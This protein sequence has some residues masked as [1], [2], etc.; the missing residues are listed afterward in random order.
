[1][2]IAF[3]A[4]SFRLPAPVEL[5]NIFYV[6]FS[7]YNDTILNLSSGYA[8]SVFFYGLVVY[9]PELSRRKRIRKHALLAYKGFRRKIITQILFASG[10]T[11][12]MDDLEELSDPLKFDEYWRFD[13]TGSGMRYYEF[14]NGLDDYY[15]ARIAME[16]EVLRDEIQFVLNAV[17]IDDEKA[18]S[19]LRNLSAFAYDMSKT[20]ADYDEQKRWG[21]FLWELLVPWDREKQKLLKDPIIEALEKI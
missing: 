16:L 13:E 9:L 18:F 12:S 20:G 14:L 15:A 5:P 3:F 7:G 21:N 11:V 10:K 2:V 1:M 6:S 17:D 4:S 8:I 19:Y